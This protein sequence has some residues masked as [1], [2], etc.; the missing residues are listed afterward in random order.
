MFSRNTKH[1]LC[2]YCIEKIF[3]AKGFYFLDDNFISINLAND[4]IPNLFL[5]LIQFQFFI[6]EAGMLNYFWKKIY[7]PRKL[8]S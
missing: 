6:K 5:L 2:K 8:F 4:Y 7:P 1:L 3:V